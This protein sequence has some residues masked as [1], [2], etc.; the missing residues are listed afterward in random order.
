MS[1][2]VTVSRVDAPRARR[3]LPR[4]ATVAFLII[5]GGIALASGRPPG[6]LPADAPDSAFSAA[7][8]MKHVEAIARQ[9][10]P[11]GSAAEDP[12]RAYIMDELK[13]LGLEP[14]IQR[15]RDARERGSESESHPSRSDAAN[16]VARWRGSGPAGKKALLL[17]AHYD[18]VRRGPGAGDDASGVAA[19]LEGLRA[20]K[21]MPPPERDIIVLINDGEEVGLH[22]ADVFASEH[23]WA[24]DVGV[25][26]NF[27]GRGNSGPS[28]MFETSDGN[29]WLIEQLARGSGFPM[30]SSLTYE[31]YR[32]MPND[33]DLTV[34]KRYGMAGFNFAFV[35]G[36]S[37]YHS[38]EDTPANLDPRTLQHQGDNLVG[39]A[40]RLGGLDLDDVR[41]DDV[42]Y[43]SIL[44]R[45]VAIYPMG[46]VVPL[47]VIAVLAYLGVLALGLA[48]GRIRL[49]EVAAGF[50]TFLAAAPA[51]VLAVGLLWFALG[52][53][54]VKSGI[55]VN[56]PNLGGMPVSRYDVALLAGSAVV[57]V[58]VAAGVFA[59][60]SRRWSWE[61]LGLGALIW[62]LAAAAATSLWMPGA[63]Y[64]FVW[65][66]L[67]ILIGQAVA[68]L[69]L[70]GRSDALV[71]SW[72]G[73]APLLV[74]HLMI[75]DGVFNG[76]NIRMAPFLMI[77]V[78]LVA[79]ALVPVAAQALGGPGIRSAA[80]EGLNL[81]TKARKD[82]NAK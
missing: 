82:E 72:L 15:P 45:L 71:A 75:I 64:A 27:E 79:A 2:D 60:S 81:I 43:F 31:V 62:W 10:H 78:V 77:P 18:S 5:V 16:I 33:T 36:L 76:L 70:R 19:I 30:A 44:Q 66:L 9:P 55:V 54:L 80:V 58:L 52:G 17:S 11:L 51:A 67:A 39:M 13:K 57:A 47:L 32:L 40:L 21:A 14:Q 28:F 3:L 25:V 24:R 56:R 37:Y 48:R 42:V 74:L 12:V 4:L 68:F 8:A 50:A 7:R 65:P 41:R 38:P 26:L 35:G 20:L 29:G 53:L 23:P 69:L 59:W 49:A 6:A 73:A 1:V 46:W 61:G 22:G 34:Y 63:S